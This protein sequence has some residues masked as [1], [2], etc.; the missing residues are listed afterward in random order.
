MYVQMLSQVAQRT[1]RDVH[2]YYRQ[3]CGFA[4]MRSGG[5]APGPT[6][7]QWA[8]AVLRDMEGLAQSGDV[9]FLPS[10][11]LTRLSDQTSS[12]NERAVHHVLAATVAADR[13]RAEKA[14][15]AVLEPLA[16]RGVHI[17]FEAPT[18]LFKSPTFRCADWFD[19]SSPVCQGGSA[20]DRSLLESY[21]APILA[22]YDRVAQDLDGVT[23]WDPL[24]TLCEQT[25]CQAM[26]GGRPLFFDGDHLSGYGNQVLLPSFI[27]DLEQLA[28]ADA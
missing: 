26:R 25:V 9:L 22:S 13:S 20:V 18:P 5:F 1:D 23:V 19:R 12:L 3:G 2:L 28:N 17:V 24:P 21:R 8:A 14:T 7:H 15:K 27:A 6:C 11:R 10:L 16:R 4:T